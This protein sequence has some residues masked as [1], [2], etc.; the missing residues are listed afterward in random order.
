MKPSIMPVMKKQCPTCPFRDTLDEDCLEVR[1][2]VV[3]RILHEASQ[4]CHHPALKGKKQTHLC[5]GA[6]DIQ[7]R[8]FKAIGFLDAATDAAWAAKVQELNLR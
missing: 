3:N 2:N 8:Y 5:R 7:L 4:I 6:R 1:K